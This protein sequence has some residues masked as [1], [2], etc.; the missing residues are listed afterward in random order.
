M[1]VSFDIGNRNQDNC[2]SNDIDNSNLDRDVSFNIDN[3]IQNGRNAI[4]KGD[5]KVMELA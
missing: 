2:G 5:I 3:G 1:D 4:D